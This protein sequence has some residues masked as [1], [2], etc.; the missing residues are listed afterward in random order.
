MRCL[1]KFK[2]FPW[3]IIG[4]LLF[5]SFPCTKTFGGASKYKSK[6]E[7]SFYNV[8]K[9]DDLNS[10]TEKF[11]KINCMIAYAKGPAL[12]TDYLRK[13]INTKD[14]SKRVDM[15]F[16]MDRRLKLFAK[17]TE[18]KS[19]PIDVLHSEPESDAFF[20]YWMC[21]FSVSTKKTLQ[22]SISCSNYD[23]VKKRLIEKYGKCV[24]NNYCESNDNCMLIVKRDKDYIVNMYFYD[25]IKEH[26]M[27]SKDGYL[28]RKKK[29][30][31]KL[32]DAF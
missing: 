18:I 32:K 24:E 2:L 13:I 27:I 22:I 31:K 29:N 8:S 14:I 7:F 10:A 6:N 3:I 25:N 26:Y 28:K 12:D 17:N 9:K 11:K 30:D 16:S 19:L 20:N 15:I 5:I 1:K 23:A 21:Y 4:M